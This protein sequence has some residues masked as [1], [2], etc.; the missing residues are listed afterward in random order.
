MDPVPAD[1][2][3]KNVKDV[4][5]NQRVI[6]D[7]LSCIK[8]YG[9]FANSYFAEGEQKK[10]Y[11]KCM[12]CTGERQKYHYQSKNYTCS[13]CGKSYNSGD[14]FSKNERSK[15]DKRCKACTSESHIRKL[16]R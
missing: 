7:K 6:P 14:C 2:R 9:L 11:P 15:I 8:C 5:Q 16:A 4:E 10:M 12:Y 3:A 13:D 1:E